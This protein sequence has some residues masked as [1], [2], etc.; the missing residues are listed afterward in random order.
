MENTKVKPGEVTKE[1]ILNAPVSQAWKAITDPDEMKNWYFKIDRFKP[2]VGFTFEFYGEAEAKK[3]LHLCE[4]TDVIPQKRLQY[5]WSYKDLP[6][7]SLLTF[8]LQ[9]EG[10]KT[11]L[12]L[13]HAGLDTFPANDPV[14]SRESFD[15]GWNEIISVLKNYLEKSLIEE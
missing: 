5:S 6:G 11:R 12:K 14:F 4:V 9:P 2:E 3:Y 13:T 7:R 8:E 1:T 15:Y 10:D